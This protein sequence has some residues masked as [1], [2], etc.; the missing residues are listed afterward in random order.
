MSSSLLTN[1]SDFA[2]VSSIIQSVKFGSRCSF[3]LQP[4]QNRVFISR[5]ATMK[6][7]AIFSCITSPA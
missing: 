4:Y 7:M 2:P 5:G 6:T 1:I 3:S